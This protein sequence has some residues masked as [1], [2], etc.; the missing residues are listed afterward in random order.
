MSV[1]DE[2]PHLKWASML[3]VG[4]VFLI[5]AMA[6]MFADRGAARGVESTRPRVKQQTSRMSQT[7]MRHRIAEAQQAIPPDTVAETRA[8]INE[9]RNKVEVDPDAPDAPALLLAMG[10]LNFRKLRDYDQAILCYEQ[11]LHRY[12]DWEGISQ[13]YSA[14]ATCYEE[15]GEHEK[16]HRIYM[17]MMDVFPE[18]SEEYYF[19][20]D[21]LGL[22]SDRFRRD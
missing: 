1:F 12:P 19:A 20:A 5:I 17:T 18:D 15:A 16:V 13:V 14:L 10:N 9:H 2:R 11:I 8:V 21:K 6:G 3:A 22:M 4:A 7:E